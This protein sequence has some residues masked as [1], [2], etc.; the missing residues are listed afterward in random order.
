MVQLSALCK[1]LGVGTAAK[2]I[3]ARLRQH[4]WL[5]PTARRG[6]WEFAPA[7]VAGA[8]SSCDPLLQVKAYAAT[9]PQDELALTF[10][11]AAW[12]LGCA[13]RIP[14]TPEVALAAAPV[15]PLQ[16]IYATAF[17]P[18]LPLQKA[19]GVDVLP[20]ESVIV[21]MSQRPSAVRSWQSVQEWLPDL[22][23]ELT[24]EALLVELEGRP[25]SVTTRAGYLLQG[26][27]PDL[28]SVLYKAVPPRSKLRFGTGTPLRNDE[29][30]LIS[31]ATLPFDPRTMEA[32]R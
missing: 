25:A 1:D 9:H 12:A 20:P 17:A 21:H 4:G 23:Y 6:V 5:I 18:R 2:V 24:Q 8:Y 31:D 32:V 30:W 3:A 15:K 28:A 16:G 13:D 27:R 22:A 19:K 29:T 11:T 10:Q 14:A 7:E 26:L